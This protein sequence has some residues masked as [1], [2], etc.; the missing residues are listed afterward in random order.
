M[1]LPK[2]NL[3]D[4]G[5]VLINSQEINVQ[6]AE[7]RKARTLG[8]SNRKSL[9][10][11]DGLLFVYEKPGKHRIWM[12]DMNFPIDIIWFDQEKKVIWIEKNISPGTY[13]QSFYPKEPASFVL[14][15]PANKTKELKINI[16]SVLSF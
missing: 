7:N 1:F 6:I 4:Q 10:P 3:F 15:L 8:L 9:E 14:E 5:T 12:K 16:G 2:N 11:F 13:P